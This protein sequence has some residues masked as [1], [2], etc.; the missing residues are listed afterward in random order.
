MANSQ[1]GSWPKWC[2]QP[3]QEVAEHFSLTV[4]HELDEVGIKTREEQGHGTRGLKG[5]GDDVA[6][7][8]AIPKAI[9]GNLELKCGGNVSGGDIVSLVM[10]PTSTTCCNGGSLLQHSPSSMLGC[11]LLPPL[12]P[13]PKPGFFSHPSNP[14]YSFWA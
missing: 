14:P 10:L 3:G 2:I 8:A 11:H 1:H 13:Q 12:E 4:P 6:Q 9:D 7:N 5:M